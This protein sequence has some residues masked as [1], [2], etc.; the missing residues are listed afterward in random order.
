MRCEG[1]TLEPAANAL[2]KLYGYQVCLLGDIGEMF[3]GCVS[4]SRLKTA[5]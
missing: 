3:A 2:I 1:G 4:E 5:V